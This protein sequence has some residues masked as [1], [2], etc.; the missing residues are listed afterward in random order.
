MARPIP[1]LPETHPARAMIVQ[2][3]NTQR[4]NPTVVTGCNVSSL[5]IFAF[6]TW[7]AIEYGR[8]IIWTWEASPART[9]QRHDLRKR[10][11]KLKRKHGL[12]KYRRRRRATYRHP[13]DVPMSRRQTVTTPDGS[14]KETVVR[15]K[16]KVTRD[17]YD[18]PY[19]IGPNGKR[20]YMY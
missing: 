18:N 11:K 15:P 6:I 3:D 16:G 5:I 13:D 9:Q 19:Y 12:G 20:V 4:N 2:H 14:T 8:K 17:E 10:A 1:G 7:I